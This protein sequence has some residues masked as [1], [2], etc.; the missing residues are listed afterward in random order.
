[1]KKFLTI[2]LLLVVALIILFCLNKQSLQKP[3]ASE[4]SFA[5]VESTPSKPE[6][7]FVE[8]MSNTAPVKAVSQL[9]N[10]II[11]IVP[12]TNALTATNI[13]QWKAL[14][15]NLHKMRGLS[16]SWHMEQTNQA[17]YVPMLLQE[18]GKTI[19]YKV[20]FIDISIKN[21]NGDI[22]EVEARSPMMDINETRE[23]GLQLC[24]MLGIDPKNFLA[25]CDTVGNHWLDAPL[26]GDG[27]RQYSFHLFRTYNDEKPWDISFMIIPNP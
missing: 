23:L 5:V 14:I 21:D 2:L 27:N 24:D 3:P 20:R 11:S 26:F 13:E 15:K 1:M 6:S 18:N 10:A 4:P 12:L 25:W 19:S 8:F 9:T 7:N 17:L 22:L 16:E